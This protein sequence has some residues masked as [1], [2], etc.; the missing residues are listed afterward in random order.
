MIN[1]GRAG[2]ADGEIPLLDA[3][4]LDDHADAAAR[5]IGGASPFGDDADGRAIGRLHERLRRTLKGRRMSDEQLEDLAIDLY[6]RACKLITSGEADE[7]QI[8]KTA[9]MFGEDPEE[10]KARLGVEEP[11]SEEEPA[12]DGAAALLGAIFGGKG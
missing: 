8:R 9:A 11:E 10:L 6:N 4:R 3:D 5:E 12:G 7:A 1:F 2:S